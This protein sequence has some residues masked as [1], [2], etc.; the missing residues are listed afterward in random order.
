MVLDLI[1]KILEYTCLPEEMLPIISTTQYQM[2][3]YIGL[4]NKE[5]YKW[6]VGD[7]NYIRMI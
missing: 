4:G 3:Y 1:T 5:C 2:K 6:R 7:Q